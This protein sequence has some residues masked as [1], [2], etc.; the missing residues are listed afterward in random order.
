GAGCRT[1]P[2]ACRWSW[3]CRP[4]DKSKTNGKVA[5]RGGDGAEGGA[6]G[7][8]GRG[9]PHRV[10]A[11]EHSGLCPGRPGGRRRIAG[12][13]DAA[14]IASLPGMGAILTAEFIARPG[15]ISRFTG[16]DAL[17]ACAGLAPVLARSGR[18]RHS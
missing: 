6:G 8:P 12:R 1:A 16:G 10:E 13:P 15:G 11:A 9:A 5:P 7:R 2:A 17:A 3:T 4:V 18:M 14:L